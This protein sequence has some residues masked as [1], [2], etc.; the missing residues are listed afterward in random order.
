MTI[1]EL[2]EE[3]RQ[4]AKKSQSNAMGIHCYSGAEYAKWLS[5]ATMYLEKHY[6]DSSETKR[7]CE[8]AR[9]ANGNTTTIFDQMI[10]ILEAFAI[11]EPVDTSLDIVG[12][13][14]QICSNFGRFDKA[15]QN[16]HANRATIQCEDE[17]DVQDALGAILRLF[18]SNIIPEDYVPSYAGMRSRVDF[19]LPDQ[20]IVIETKMT[21]QGLTDKEVGNELIIDFQHY[22]LLPKCNH[23]I[24]FVYDKDSYIENPKGLIS[25]LERMSDSEMKM[26][27]IIAPQL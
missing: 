24:C 11:Q 10:G 14:R 19:H 18:E 25:D 17:Y 16:R 3:G 13:I 7:F 5:M 6:P 27:V 26:T 1:Q 8:L 4:A 2:I 9:R 22:K 23:L 12:I 20:K 15:I 21:R